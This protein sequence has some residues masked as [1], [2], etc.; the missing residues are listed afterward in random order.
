L[1]TRSSAVAVI[2]DWLAEKSSLLRDFCC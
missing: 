2:A 1:I